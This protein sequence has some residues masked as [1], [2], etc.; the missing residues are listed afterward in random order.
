MRA[1][2]RIGARLGTIPGLAVF[3]FL[4]LL[5]F[6]AA[7]A[8]PK[9][10]VCSRLQCLECAETVVTAPSKENPLG[11]YC[12]RCRTLSNCTPG[13]KQAPRPGTTLWR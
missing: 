4:S 1:R 13:I 3:G 10:A 11:E 8:A 5:P 9:A 12:I 2:T 7:D 6:G